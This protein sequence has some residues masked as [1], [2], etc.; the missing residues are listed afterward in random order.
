MLTVHANVNNGTGAGFVDVPNGTVHQ[1]VADERGWRDGDVHD[2]PGCRYGGVV[3]HGR[4]RRSLPGDDQLAD[5]GHDDDQRLGD[6]LGRPVPV[7]PFPAQVSLTRT[8]NGVGANSG[9]ATKNW[10]DDAVTT[11]VLNAANR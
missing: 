2:R 4:G 11:T 3:V 9:P 1:P 8:T 7:P 5:D 6:D 10:A